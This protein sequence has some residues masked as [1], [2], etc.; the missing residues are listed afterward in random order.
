MLTTTTTMD[1]WMDGWMDEHVTHPRTHTMRPHM[2]CVE[3]YVIFYNCM[4]I[5]VLVLRRIY[6][7]S[8]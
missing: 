8:V 5:R 7:S 4:L 6:I 2:I 3:V 1:G